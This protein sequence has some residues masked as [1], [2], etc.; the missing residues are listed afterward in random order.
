VYPPRLVLLAAKVPARGPDSSGLRDEAALAAANFPQVRKW[1]KGVDLFAKDFLFVPIHD[2]LH[3]S[4]IIVC[5]PGA[6][7]REAAGGA[8]GGGGGGA[9]G[10]RSSASAGGGR[11]GA[12]PPDEGGAD[13]RAAPAPEPFLLHLDSMRGG[14]ASVG[15]AA[16]LQQYLTDE[17]R[18][19][20]GAGSEGQGEGVPRAWADAHPGAPP[21][22][23]SAANLRAIK[24]A[25]PAQTNHCDCGLFVCAYVEFFTAALPP[26]LNHAAVTA[27]RR[28]YARDGRE[29]W[30]AAEAEAGA[31]GAGASQEGQG[32]GGAMEAAPGEE[33]QG[34]AMAPAPA[35][36]LAFTP[37][38]G[39]LTR[40]WFLPANASNLRWELHKMM[41][42]RMGVSAC[43]PAPPCPSVAAERNARR[44]PAP[45]AH[46]PSTSP[47]LFPRSK[48]PAFW[49]PMACRCWRTASLPS[50]R[51][52]WRRCWMTSRP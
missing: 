32:G 52:S 37:F 21:R 7:P 6:E 51:P 40:E 22:A 10:R 1:T 26:A 8:G 50:G 18:V 39:F 13:A 33:G 42:L 19:R 5:H 38:P 36:A 31:A 34:G 12:T 14:H 4:L 30:E 15:P 23:F 11:A 48:M 46:P 9:R 27:L 3:W 2:N 20:A 41:L 35:P 28:G 44:C 49:T 17:W 16:V 25:V 43:R 45:P 24:P 29:L 47:P